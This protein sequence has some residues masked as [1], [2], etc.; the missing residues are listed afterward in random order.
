MLFVCCC[1]ML[2]LGFSVAHTAAN[3]PSTQHDDYRGA[4]QECAPGE[5]VVCPMCSG[6]TLEDCDQALYYEQCKLVTDTCITTSLISLRGVVEIVV[7]GCGPATDHCPAALTTSSR[8][9]SSKTRCVNDVDDDVVRCVTCDDDKQSCVGWL[10]SET[11]KT[12]SLSVVVSLLCIITVILTVSLVKNI[13]DRR[14]HSDYRLLP[15]YV[16]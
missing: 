4:V 3:D 9:T 12:V 5:P 16:K 11:V 8:T 6:A 14:R 1:V 13:T 10:T 2:L 7:R 15:E